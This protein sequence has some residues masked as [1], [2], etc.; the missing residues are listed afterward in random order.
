MATSENLELTRLQFEDHGASNAHF[1]ARCGPRFFRETADHWL[2]L[3]QRDVV[4]KSVLSG[5]GLCWSV[6]DNFAVIH[7]SSQLVQTQAVAAEVAFQC[8]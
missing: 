8:R 7:T 1:L 5:Y 3:G 6:W 4:L 2:G